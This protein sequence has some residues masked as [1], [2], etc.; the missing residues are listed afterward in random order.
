MAIKICARIW[1]EGCFARCLLNRAEVISRRSGK[2]GAV[3]AAGVSL[4][5]MLVPDGARGGRQPESYRK[6]CNGGEAQLIDE[7]KFQ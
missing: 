7:Q 1:R 6:R 2:R 3:S 4:I 5:T